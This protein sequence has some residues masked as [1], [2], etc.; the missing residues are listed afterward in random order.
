MIQKTIDNN[1][2]KILNPNHT[3][4]LIIDGDEMEFR[5]RLEMSLTV[6]SPVV[7]FLIQGGLNALEDVLDSLK[8]KIPIVLVAVRKF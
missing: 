3:N 4:F 6:E 8:R 5:R 7:I 2:G 1:F